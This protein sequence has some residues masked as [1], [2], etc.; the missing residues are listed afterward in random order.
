MRST[1]ITEHTTACLKVV[2]V[3]FGHYYR[4]HGAEYLKRDIILQYVKFNYNETL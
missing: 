3:N 2:L 4:G 1:T